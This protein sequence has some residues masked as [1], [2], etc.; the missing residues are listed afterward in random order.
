MKSR[1]LLLIPLLF[2]STSFKVQPAERIWIG[3][4]EVYFDAETDEFILIYSGNYQ[5]C[6]TK[7]VIDHVYDDCDSLINKKILDEKFQWEGSEIDS[8]LEIKPKSKPTFQ[9]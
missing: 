4:I 9:I 3:T 1:Y 7:Y 2:L 6:F 8:C 5:R